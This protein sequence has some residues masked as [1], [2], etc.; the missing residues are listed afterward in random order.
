MLATCPGGRTQK[1]GL[2]CTA[3]VLDLG[4]PGRPPDLPAGMTQLRV[5]RGGREYKIDVDNPFD[6]APIRRKADRK[7]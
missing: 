6:K 2:K 4:D 3:I 7:R 5:V 1:Y